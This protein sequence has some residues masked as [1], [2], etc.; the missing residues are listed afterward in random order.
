M[1][2]FSL[3]LSNGR[4]SKFAQA[5]ASSGRQLAKNVLALEC[6][7]GYA[8]LLENVL[9]FPSDALLP[10]PVSQLQQG[11]WEWNLFEDEIDLGVHLQKI[12]DDSSIGKLSIVYALEQ[13]LAGLNNSISAPEHETEVLMHDVP[14]KLD[15][16]ILQ[17]IETSEENE[18]LEMEEVGCIANVAII[19]FFLPTCL[20]PFLEKLLWNLRLIYYRELG[21][22]TNNS[23]LL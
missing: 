12:D 13:E 20:S 21:L 10:G 9:S 17:E 11:K 16:D 3:L 14:T 5:I 6:T 15:W 19:L 2:A 8:R 4:L 22:K 23:F 18:M 7:T 1:S